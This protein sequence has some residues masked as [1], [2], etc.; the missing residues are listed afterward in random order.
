MMSSSDILGF[1]SLAGYMAMLVWMFRFGFG[2]DKNRVNL[3]NH[4]PENFSDTI[5]TARMVSPDQGMITI[6]DLKSDYRVLFRSYNFPE[7][8]SGL[9][10]GFP[11]TEWSEPHSPSLCNEL[12]T[13]GI[14][15]R[16]ARETYGD[17]GAGIHVD[18]G[19][20]INKAVDLARL[21]LFDLYGLSPD[22]RFQTSP[23]RWPDHED[24]VSADADGYRPLRDFNKVMG[25]PSLSLTMRAAAY[26]VGFIFCSYP[27]LW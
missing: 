11:V 4:G 7:G 17:F 10:F 16:E 9:E 1:L 21:C 26:A 23:S 3:S 18:C 19:K 6:T 13:R 27:A 20:D 5:R 2:R 24:V 12:R 15:F 14:P 8:G 25:M 22:S